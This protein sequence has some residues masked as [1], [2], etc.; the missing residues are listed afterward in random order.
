MIHRQS[1]AYRKS[2]RVATKIDWLSFDYAGDAVNIHYYGPD[3]DYEVSIDAA[4]LDRIYRFLEQVENQRKK[5][6]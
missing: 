6:A 3:H 2:T 1:K 4:E 5:F